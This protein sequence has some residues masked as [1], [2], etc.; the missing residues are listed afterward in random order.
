MLAASYSDT[1]GKPGTASNLLKIGGD[2]QAPTLSISSDRPS[3]KAGETATI[4]FSFNETPLGFGL[5]DLI[6]SGGTLDNL[7]RGSDPLSYTA[8]F[9]PE[10]GNN[11]LKA[12]IQ[13]DNEAFFDAAGN[14]GTASQ[15]LLLS[16]DTLLPGLTL[17]SDK[18]RLKTGET[19]TLTFNF[20]EMPSGFDLSDIVVTGGSLGTLNGNGLTRTALFTP[21]ANS[22]NVAASVSVAAGSY[23]DTAGNNGLASN[24]VSLTADTLA[25]G[26]T[27]S[28]DKISLKAGDNSILTPRCPDLRE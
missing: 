17:G 18:T 19:A 24:A 14:P 27:I 25:P 1:I 2:T 15:A 6:V 12:N 5:D 22:N 4:N 10:A 23:T 3:L 21:T 11:T 26:L 9:T 8:R 16:G 7:S 13:I 20:T 28:S